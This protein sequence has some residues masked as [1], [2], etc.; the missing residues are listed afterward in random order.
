MLYSFQC[1]SI[2]FPWLSV[3]L[4]V[5]FFGYYSKL[6]CFL[7]FLFWLFFASLLSAHGWFL[8][9]HFI[10][11]NFAKFICSNTG[12]FF[13][14]FVYCLRFSIYRIMSSANG[15]KLILP[16]NLD[17][18]PLY[19]FMPPSSLAPGNHSF[20][21]LDH[22]VFSRM[23]CSWNHTVYSFFKLVSFTL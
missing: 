4:G 3:F 11:C 6:N 12:F 15:D 17:A 16:S 19:L 7:N 13:G 2:S 10:Y 22:S 18:F 21:C 8:C 23:S 20:Y 1:T 14:L 9:V 5:L